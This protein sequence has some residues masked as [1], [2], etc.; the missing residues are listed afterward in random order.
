[1]KVY[2]KEVID[3]PKKDITKRANNTLGIDFV[4]CEYDIDIL[5]LL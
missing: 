1:M 2:G 3:M 5:Y 4:Y